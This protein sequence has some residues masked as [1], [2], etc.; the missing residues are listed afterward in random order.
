MVTASE[1]TVNR[2]KPN[3]DAILSEKTK[4]MHLLDFIISK[5]FLWTNV[6]CCGAVF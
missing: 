4:N 2:K 3:I 1:A 5:D 6:V